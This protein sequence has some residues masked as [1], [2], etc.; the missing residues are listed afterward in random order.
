MPRGI[1]EQEVAI[2]IKKISEGANIVLRNGSE[3]IRKLST[4]VDKYDCDIGN[5][6]LI[7]FTLGI[8][9]EQHFYVT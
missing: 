9:Y 2:V 3:I 8:L 4:I 7:D 5:S 6:R 1:S